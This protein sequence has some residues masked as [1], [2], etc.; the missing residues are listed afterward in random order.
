MTIPDNFELSP[1]KADTH[2][3]PDPPK[4]RKKE[5]YNDTDAETFFAAIDNHAVE[6]SLIFISN[7]I[8]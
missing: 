3:P 6:V 1:V 7:I 5:L 8:Y 4:H 2:P